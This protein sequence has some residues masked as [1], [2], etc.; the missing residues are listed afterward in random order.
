MKKSTFTTLFAPVLGGFVIALAGIAGFTPAAANAQP[1]YGQYSYAPYATCVDLTYTLSPGSTD[2]GTS[3]QVSQLQ[4]FL[5]Q[6]GYLSGVSG[7]F[8]NGTLGAVINYQR[9]YDLPITGIADAQTEAYMNQQSCASG[10]SGYAGSYPSTNYSNGSNCY[11]TGGSSNTYVCNSQVVTPV[12]SYNSG[13]YNNSNYNSNYYNSGSYNN[14][15]YNNSNYCNESNS[16]YEQSLSYGNTYNSCSGYNRVILNALSA[17]YG[18]NTVTLTV[19]GVGF[20]LTGNTVYFGNT[21]IAN[22]SSPNGTTLS[23][24]VPAGFTTG[25]YGVTVTNAS[26]STSNVLSYIMSNSYNNGYNPIYPDQNTSGYL[27]NAP[28]LS[29]ISG[30]SEVSVGQNA[31]WT[32]TAYNGSSYYGNGASLSVN[33]GDAYTVNAN[34]T[35]QAYSNSNQTYSFSHVYVTPGTYTIRITATSVTG[36][37]TSSTY[38]VTVG[39]SSIYNNGY[40]SS[41]YPNYN[42]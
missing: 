10:V 39:G 33:W 5:N 31:T 24:T 42:Y 18:Y 25:T 34:N 40:Y 15:Y 12:S 38:I 19:T 7:T 35:Q 14:G 22:V 16:F 28:T 26:G 9:A 32:V 1:Y 41:S 30:P 36:Q 3:G 6:T 27:N 17:S 8:D 11:W 23:F 20:S 4:E 2:A 37:T 21:A 29:N 13:Y